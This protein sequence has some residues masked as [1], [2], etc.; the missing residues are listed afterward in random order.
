MAKHNLKKT[1]GDYCLYFK[2]FDDDFIILLLYIDAMLIVSHDL[3]KINKLKK[4]LNK[5]F[6]MKDLE[7]TKK[8]MGMHI[9]W[10]RSSGKNWLSQE[11]Y[12][13]KVIKNLGWKM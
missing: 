6:E 5:S 4:E 3:N 10:Y 8:I 1:N 11:N 13:N 7:L 9:L 2:K 12:V